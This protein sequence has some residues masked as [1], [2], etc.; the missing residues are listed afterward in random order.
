MSDY[1]RFISYLYCYEN[2][3]KKNNIG[4]ARIETRNNQC[5]ITIHIKLLS[6]SNTVLDTYLFYRKNHQIIGLPLCPLTVK[7]SVG[8]CQIVTSWDKVLDSDLPFSMI[9]GIIISISPTR[10]L[11][12]EW[13]DIPII[14]SSFEAEKPK[15]L[16]AADTETE[17]VP[18]ASVPAKESQ[19]PVETNP[20]DT[21][22]NTEE[23]SIPIDS[24]SSDSLSVAGETW[25]P[26]EPQNIK[27]AKQIEE[28]QENKQTQEISEIKEQDNT[29]KAQATTQIEETPTPDS[30]NTITNYLLIDPAYIN[31]LS[32]DY[33]GLKQNSF[34]LHGYGSYR[35]LILAKW[36][37]NSQ[38]SAAE[39]SKDPDI[40]K[41]DIFYQ[42]GVPG[43]YSTREKA[44]AEKFGFSEFKTT[45]GSPVKYGDFGYWLVP[46]S[47]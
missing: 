2:G 37:V 44:I 47:F 40:M 4:Y 13:D 1:K 3:I 23:A 17:P 41:P 33:M 28:T 25:K 45:K 19:I 16:S 10:L 11:G 20:P 32:I 43:I 24:D 18:P 6:V 46:V 12:T 27:E 39:A 14:P 38:V 22:S 21:S 31:H 26:T 29:I 8:D 34:L 7:N 9:G 5:K 36:M 30:L 35:H 42:L 15:T